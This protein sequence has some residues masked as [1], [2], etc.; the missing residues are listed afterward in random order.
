METRLSSSQQKEIRREWNL[1]EDDFNN[2]IENTMRSREALLRE[3]DEAVRSELEFE[4][5]PAPPPYSAGLFGLEYMRRLRAALIRRFEGELYRHQSAIYK[6][7]C[8]DF[9]YC[10]RRRKAEFESEGYSVALGVA[11]A[12]LTA[13]TGIPLP[14]TTVSVYLV[15]KMLLDRWCGC[16]QKAT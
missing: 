10:D 5:K 15:K 3:V 16:G 1:S 6:A 9:R 7:V 11:D 4:G 14:V 8:V 12:L 2:L 13:G